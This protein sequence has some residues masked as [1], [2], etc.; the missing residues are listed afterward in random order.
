VFLPPEVPIPKCPPKRDEIIRL[1]KEEFMRYQ[2]VV[3]ENPREVCERMWEEE[4]EMILEGCRAMECEKWYE[5]CKAEWIP[6]EELP[7]CGND[8][9]EV[10]EG[11]N[12]TYSCVMDCGVDCDGD[13]IRES[14]V[15]VEECV[16]GETMPYI[17]TDGT[18]VEWCSCVEGKWVCIEEPELEC[19]TLVTEC[20]LTCEAC[21]VLNVEECVCEPV[22]PCCGNEVC[23]E[24]ETYENCPED[25]PS[26]TTGITGAVI[27]GI[28]SITGF[29]AA[30][31]IGETCEEW[32][33]RCL[34]ERGVCESKEEFIKHCLPDIESEIRRS[35]EEA[36]IECERQANF[37]L[38][39]MRRAC[40][41]MESH[42]NRCK[43]DLEKERKFLEKMLDQCKRMTTD[44]VMEK[45]SE[46]IA[47]EF[48]MWVAYRPPELPILRPEDI[49][50]LG[51][52]IVPI[53]ISVR[54]DISEEE[55]RILKLIVEDIYYVT[56]ISGLKI[57]KATIRAD[58]FEGVKELG[59]VDDAKL[60]HVARVMQVRRGMEIPPRPGEMP[61]LSPEEILSMLEAV[62]MQIPQE[63]RPWLSYE[64]KEIV[65]VEEVVKQIERKDIGYIIKW[66]VG[67]AADQE[68]AEGEKLAEEVVKLNKTI[69][70]LTQLASQL[71]DADQIA[72]LNEQI[73]ELKDRVA[74]LEQ[75][76]E[77]KKKLARGI[78][79]LVTAFFGG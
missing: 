62:K 57:Y 40:K 41:E 6:P 31:E 70:R 16:S 55:E 61:P 21:E 19:P 12:E 32:R 34:E 75:M 43:R 14:W 60:D 13:G 10:E 51:P 50:R 37:M 78:V 49:P 22:V 24:N 18:E 46:M 69:E 26:P 29:I 35:K 28:S 64:E 17:C 73:D 11:E 4:K 8:I 7:V 44:E 63:L 53:V 58:K 38:R 45:V 47:A 66:L 33:D 3:E 79:D 71:K 74:Y 65:S 39:E 5:E 2:P 48:C 76:G 54:A 67:L 77:R 23:E 20:V 25:C 72:L 59:F 52:E 56:E 30:E 36:D 9:C 15:C 27:R 68:K 1:C 42:M